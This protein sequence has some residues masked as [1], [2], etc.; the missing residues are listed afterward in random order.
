LRD[1]PEV[2]NEE[3]T[4][5]KKFPDSCCFG[6]FR[7]PDSIWEF[8]MKPRGGA[9]ESRPPALRLKSSPCTGSGS[10]PGA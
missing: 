8:P 5:D 2:R 6:V 4:V 7:P 1:Q 9:R 3:T 10:H